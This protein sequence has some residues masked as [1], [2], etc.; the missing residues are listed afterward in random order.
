MQLDSTGKGLYATRA[1]AKGDVVLRERPLCAIQHHDNRGH[2]LVCGACFC[3]LGSL[4]EQLAWQL[5]RLAS[6]LPHGT[7]TDSTSST[8]PSARAQMSQL[9]RQWRPLL[10]P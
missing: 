3:F 10:L 8:T 1:F 6:S 5:M 4:E 9:Q 2:A 7:R